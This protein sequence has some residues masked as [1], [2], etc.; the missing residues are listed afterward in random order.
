MATPL[1]I[2]IALWYYTTRQGDY[3]PDDIFHRNSSACK[4]IYNKFVKKQLLYINNEPIVN[5]NEP[6]YKAGPALECYINALCAIPF[7]VQQWVIPDVD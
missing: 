6:T 3:S 2:Q 5:H 7:P 4:F 1:E